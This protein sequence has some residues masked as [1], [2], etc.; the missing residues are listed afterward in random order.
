[1]AYATLVELKTYADFQD[2]DDDDL[3]TDLIES[4]QAIIDLFTGRTFETDSDDA[5]RTFDAVEDVDGRTLFLD[6]DLAALTSITN[7]DGTSYADSDGVF[8]TEPRNSTP[9]WG[10]TLKASAG[11]YW[12]NDSDGDPEDAIS[13]TGKWAYSTT[14]PA[15]IKQACI[16]LAS[17]LYKMRESDET[18]DRPLLTGDGVTIMPARLPGDAVD[19][20]KRYRRLKVAG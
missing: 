11:L 3:L 8:V 15:D 20:L 5:T 17:W 10:I 7:G 2:S 16:R 18:A 13:M 1:M 6:E 9:Y 4:A 12:Q 19:I 14:A